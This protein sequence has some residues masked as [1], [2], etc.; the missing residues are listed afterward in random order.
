MAQARAIVAATPAGA[1]ARPARLGALAGRL[2]D[3]FETSLEPAT[4]AEAL[5]VSEE[6]LRIAGHSS[7]DRPSLLGGLAYALLLRFA[8]EGKDDDLDGAITLAQEAVG[9]APAVSP[10][11]AGFAL[12]LAQAWS[13]RGGRSGGTEDLDH[14]TAAFRL[15]SDLGIRRDPGAALRAARAWG[16]WAAEEHRWAEA[17]QAFGGAMTATEGLY[18]RQVGRR[19]RE[20]WLRL[21]PGLPADAALASARAGAREDAVLALERGRARMLSDALD[22]DRAAVDTLSEA[23]QEELATRFKSAAAEVSALERHQDKTGEH[24]PTALAAAR[25]ALDL[26]VNEIRSLPGHESFLAP[27]T[28]ADVIAAASLAK[29]PI[30]YIASATAGGVVAAIR[31]DGPP[32]VRVV[33]DFDEAATRAR[34]GA[35]VGAARS[36]AEDPAGWRAELTRT[37]DWLGEVIWPAILEAAGRCTATVLVPVGLLGLLPFH[38]AARHDP[39]A[40][41]GRRYALDDVLVT[42]APNARTL[43]A[44]HHRAAGVAGNRVLAVGASHHL[45]ETP[46]PYGDLEAEMVVAASLGGRH[47]PADEATRA[48]VLGALA[49]FDVVHLAC[50]GRADLFDPLAGG[51]LLAGRDELTL[52]DVLGLRLTGARLA[53]LS[54]CESA[55]TGAALPDEVVSL[56]TGLLQAGFAGV[57]GSLWQV[58]DASTLLLMRRFVDEWQRGGAEPAEALRRAQQWVRDATNREREAAYPH[59]PELGRPPAD[60][61]LHDI[62]A[63]RRTGMHPHD[64]AA[65]AYIGV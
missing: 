63:D 62:W 32:V 39:S 38:A 53:V 65:F 31:G 5:T 28:F 1:R 12:T 60:V 41:T 40:P 33:A 42:Y 46:L 57:V 17:A 14:A 4:L 52:R 9:S 6:G 20:S 56:P 48:E 11:R 45:G 13:L 44:S 58:P 50:H 64:W 24:D 21:A 43:T 22:L 10:E 8:V 19:N 34:V 15:A 61:R 25:A 59:A 35:F 16:A 27:A 26:V 7:V 29:G 51:L 23:G 30:I 36:R 55:V 47:I 49:E 3:A 54:A 18:R 37:T 2:I